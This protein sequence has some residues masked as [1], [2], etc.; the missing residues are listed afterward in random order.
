MVLSP[1]VVLYRNS[2]NLFT[3]LPPSA[4]EYLIPALL[5]DEAEAQTEN[6]RTFQNHDVTALSQIIK[7]LEGVLEG[8]ALSSQKEKLLPVLAS[9]TALSRSHR[10]IRKYCR[11]RVSS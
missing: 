10:V 8:V 4:A 3:A 9:L 7:Y 6:Y 11:L 5:G 2:A 1:P